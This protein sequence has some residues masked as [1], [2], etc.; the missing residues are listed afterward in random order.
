MIGEKD[1]SSTNNI[2]GKFN[3]VVL[4]NFG[5]IQFGGSQEFL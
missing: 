5:Q 4:E 3:S 1:I 2:S